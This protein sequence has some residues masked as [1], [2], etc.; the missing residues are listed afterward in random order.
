MKRSADREAIAHLRAALQL[1]EQMSDSTERAAWEL[2]ILIA[3]GPPLLITTRSAAPEIASCLLAS[4]RA[5][6]TDWSHGGALPGAVG[7]VDKPLTAGDMHGAAALVDQLLGSRRIRPGDELMLQAHHAAWSTACGQGDLHAALRSLEAGVPIYRSDTHARHALVYAGH[8]P[9]VCGHGM[10]G[11][12]WRFSVTLIELC[13]KPTKRFR[14][15]GIC[16][17]T[18][19]CACLLAGLRGPLSAARCGDSVAASRTRCCLSLPITALLCR[20][21]MR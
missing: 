5:C 13:L 19:A 9:R 17:I 6:T 11:R 2:R 10:K 15:G 14:W 4:P 18:A 21:P 12:S 16:L 20:S 7:L 1:L 8:D 3:L